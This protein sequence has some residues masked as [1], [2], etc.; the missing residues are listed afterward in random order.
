MNK[1]KLALF[2]Q[3][4]LIGLL[5]LGCSR[6]K[7]VPV[8]TATYRRTDS[9]KVYV[10]RPNVPYKELG[11]ITA[12]GSD[13]DDK[14]LFDMLKEKAMSV[15]AQ[16]IIMSPPSQRSRTIMAP[17]PP[18]GTPLAPTKTTRV[19]GAIAI[20]FN[21]QSVSPEAIL[22]TP[23]VHLSPEAE[24]IPPEKPKKSTQTI[25]PPEK[26]KL[27]VTGTF[28]NIRSG[29]GNEFSV[30]TILKQG[31]QLFLIGEYGDWYHVRLE[32]GQEGWINNRFAK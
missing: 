13:Y 2:I 6:V 15:G 31:E 17:V 22:P 18:G 3:I 9:I 8:D 26:H 16:G 14:K 12:E 23:K 25:S 24:T 11:I 10:E 1:L 30:I 5:I 7:Y 4:C 20:R 27:S 32:N 21:E 19:L 28:A 29:A